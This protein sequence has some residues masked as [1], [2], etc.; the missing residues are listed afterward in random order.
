MGVL[1][2][3]GY[4]QYEISNYAK[5]GHECQHNLAYWLGRDY[6]GLGPSAFSTIDGTRWQNTPDT[7]RY[8]EQLRRGSN[9]SALRKRSPAGSATQK[10]L[11]LACAPREESPRRR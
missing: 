6:L 9:Q 5:P 8:I 4:P 1:E 11:P 7:S 3:G 2:G 10:R